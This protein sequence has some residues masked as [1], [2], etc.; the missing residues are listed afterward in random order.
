MSNISIKLNLRQ[1]KNIVKPMRRKDGST[2]E[3]LVLPIDSNHIFR[4]GKG[5]Y[6]DLTAIEIKNKVG[7]SKD[8]HLVKQSI[9]KEV[10]EKMTEEQKKS[11]PIIGNAIV[12]DRQ[13]PEPVQAPELQDLPAGDNDDLTF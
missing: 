7:D 4:G 1:L 3:C 9:P 6:L 8:T 12:W 2:V 13:E 11:L 5:L 10:Y